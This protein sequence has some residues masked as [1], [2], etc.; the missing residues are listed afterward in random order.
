M[1]CFLS[2]HLFRDPLL[3]NTFS[4][5]FRAIK[6]PLPPS[7]LALKVIARLMPPIFTRPEHEKLDR[8]FFAK[9][10][11]RITISF[12]TNYRLTNG[13][14]FSIFLGKEICII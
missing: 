14:L 11:K 12:V 7:P 5:V 1:S 6:P 2:A 9:F 10:V 3:P 8:N 4:G 13:L